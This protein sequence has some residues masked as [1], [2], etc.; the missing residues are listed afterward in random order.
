[1]EHSYFTEVGAVCHACMRD[2]FLKENSLCFLMKLGVVL[3]IH[4][5]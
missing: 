2:M 3:S 4:T 5:L 1:M